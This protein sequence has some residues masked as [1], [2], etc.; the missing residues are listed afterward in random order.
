MA[1][2]LKHILIKFTAYR[3]SIPSYYTGVFGYSIT[4]QLASSIA[5]F[6]SSFMVNITAYNVSDIPCGRMFFLLHFPNPL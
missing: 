3:A 6:I 1:N 5:V 4:Q 2:Y